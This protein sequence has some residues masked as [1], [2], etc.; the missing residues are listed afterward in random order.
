MDAWYPEDGDPSVIGN[1][2]T[3]ESS[4]VDHSGRTTTGG[5]PDACLA[6]PTP[7]P[8]GRV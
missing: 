5:W 1:R 6:W 7:T 8:T 3:N 2:P 4:I